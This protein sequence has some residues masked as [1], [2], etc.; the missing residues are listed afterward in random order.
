M[1]CINTLLRIQ[2]TERERLTYPIIQLPLE[3]TD[4]SNRFFKNKLMWLGFSIAALIS[5]MNLLNSI[6]PAV[7]YIPVKRQNL[8]QFFTVRPWNAMG[9]FRVSFYPFVIG[10]GFLIP[11]DLL[12]SCWMFFTESIRSKLM[13]GN[14]M[15]WRNLP[16]L[17]L[18]QRTGI[19]CLRCTA[20]ICVVD[21]QSPFQR[22]SAPS[23]R[24]IFRSMIP[25][26]RCHTAWQSPAY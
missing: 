7:P 25:V 10:I 22:I 16:A 20:R 2:W 6:Y 1:L 13:V 3:M 18:F 23:A 21:R 4:T 15:G 9:S 24:L 19:G 14:I 11:L 26:N 8:H 12:F 5:I 17:S